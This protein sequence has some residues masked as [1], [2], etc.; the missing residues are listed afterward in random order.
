MSDNLEVS[1]QFRTNPLSLDPG[2]YTVKVIHDNG[3]SLSYDK[4]KNPFRYCTKV[5]D[6][7]HEIYGLVVKILVDERLFWDREKGFYFKEN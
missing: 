7:S 3:K 2:G 6:S 1:D 4:I 5:K